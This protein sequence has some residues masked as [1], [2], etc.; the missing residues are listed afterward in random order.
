MDVVDS[1][2]APAEVMAVGTDRVALL[3]IIVELDPDEAVIEAP[4]VPEEVMLN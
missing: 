3:M 2:A 4:A 1:V